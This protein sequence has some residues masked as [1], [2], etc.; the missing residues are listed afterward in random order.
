MSTLI[1]I[2][3]PNYNG[4]ATIGKC[5][6]AAYA[7]ADDNFEVVVIDDSSVDNSAEIIKE[8]PCK[9]IRLDEHAGASR[10][11]NV[12]AQNS[13]GEILFFIDADCLVLEKSLAMVRQTLAEKGASVIIGGTYTAMPYDQG[14]F[15]TFQSVFI[16]YFET[17]NPGSPDYIATHAM[18]ID[19]GTFRKSG[20]FVEDF[21]PIL[22]DVEFSH[23]LRRQGCSLYMN[24][25]I[26]VRHIFNFSFG[27]S[28]RNAIRKSRFWTE[29]SARNRDLLADSGTAS[30]ELKINVVTAF[31]IMGLFVV[32][33]FFQETALL[34]PVVPLFVFNLFVNRKLLGAYRRVGGLS[35]LIPATIYYT[36]PY[37]MAVGYGA[38][39]GIT[40]YLWG[41][42]G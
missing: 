2:I 28:M 36:L 39:A 12:G 37:S 41:R 26:L 20:G 13:S 30:I 3:I 8:F 10:A 32:G 15:S 5:L 9:L 42:R 16:N 14:F 1:S 25:E 31:I 24:P 11:R 29:Y 19:A 6:A 35:L 21:L 27:R 34:Y 4:S 22:E 40:R 38:A 18:V 23:R 17:K 33:H 7:S